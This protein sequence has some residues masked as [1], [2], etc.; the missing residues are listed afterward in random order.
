MSS[1]PL[2]RTLAVALV[3]APTAALAQAPTA[4]RAAIVA[5]L[6]SI[7]ESGV[8]AGRVVGLTV[9][10]L[11]GN[12]TLLLKGYGKADVELNVPT[13]A[14]A[15]YEIGSVTKQ[16]T[17]AAILQLRD[18][19]KLD[20]DADMS[21]YLPDFPTQGR[22]ISVRRLLD[23][24]S[25]IKGITELPEFP[26][27]SR[28]ALPRDSAIALIARQRFEFE[29]G[30]AQ[31]YNNSAYILL[32]L[33]IERQ[34]GMSYEDYI[35]KNIF[36]KLGMTRSRYCSNTEVVEG[37]AHGHTYA[38]RE[39]RLADYADLRWPYAAG[40]LCSTAADMVTWLQALHGG[41][42][43]PPKSYTDMTTPS[44]L[45]DG[46]PTRYGMGISLA[47]DPRGARLISHGGAIEGFLSH[48]SWY[49]DQR[50]AVVVLMNSTGPLSPAGLSRELAAQII[51]SVSRSVRPFAGD[52]SA[53]VGTYTG[54]GRGGPTTVVITKAA[55]GG[56]LVSPNGAPAQPAIW[57]DGL[58]FQSGPMEL[59]FDTRNGGAPV[60]HVSGSTSHYVLKRP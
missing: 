35:E 7:A 54:P 27:L 34:S 17:A 48:A 41:K 11:Q 59:R 9:A 55:D 19:G 4:S 14:N 23:H 43:L 30:E 36:A 8:K 51:P 3:L 40:S 32:G 13:P 15:V 16:F 10:V 42:V 37:R 25:G 60:L 49:P 44:K 2:L 47:N 33:I 39:L 45:A 21:R 5:G 50:V 1:H 38:G 46:T 56:I 6:D 24:T 31:V 12:D 58:T 52:A 20:L 29:P 57:I 28:R 18:A 22:K 26:D 53:L